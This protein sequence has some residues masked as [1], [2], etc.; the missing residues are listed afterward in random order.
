MKKSTIYLITVAL[1]FGFNI[2]TQ[3]DLQSM[4]TNTGLTSIIWGFFYVVE[5][6]ED[7]E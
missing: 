1:V 3:S 2:L 6:I 4:L 5:A 7:K